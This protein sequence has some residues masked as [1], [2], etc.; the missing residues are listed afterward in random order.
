MQSTFNTL[1]YFQ[2]SKRVV[3]ILGMTTTLTIED[4][5]D[6]DK[7]SKDEKSLLD[8]AGA[9]VADVVKNFQESDFIQNWDLIT[10]KFLFASSVLVFFSKFTFLMKYNYN[11]DALVI[12]T[13]GAYMNALVFACTY[14]LDN[15]REDA[16]FSH[17]QNALITLLM[18]LTFACY[19]PFFVS[20]L[21]ICI[22]LILCRCYLNSNWVTLFALRKNQALSNVNESIG[23]IAGLTTP[24][25]F[26]I[27]C[28]LIEHHAVVW[29]TV[30]PIFF[31]LFIFSQ[32]T[33]WR[34]SEQ[35]DN[36]QENVKDKD[37]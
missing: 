32:H 4:Q 9:R 18:S 14:I 30:F 35:V 7:E 19:A 37:E 27:V 29:F 24:I 33:K 36:T 22:P 20:Y 11:A 16:K 34:I 15:F 5:D 8:K 13:T 26:G 3:F 28:D 12:G 6:E 17:M 10:L 1:T 25:A 21:L 31:S 23:I 2:V